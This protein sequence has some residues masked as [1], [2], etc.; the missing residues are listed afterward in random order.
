M[1]RSFRLNSIISMYRKEQDTEE[2]VL[3]MVLGTH[4]I[5]GKVYSTPNRR[6]LQCPQKE[7]YIYIIFIKYF[8]IYIYPLNVNKVVG[9]IICNTKTI[10]FVVSIIVVYIFVC[11]CTCQR[12]TCGS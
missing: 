8:Y 11:C 7:I 4:W 1:H 9:F 5:P 12:T 2:L 10:F 3:A 6:Y